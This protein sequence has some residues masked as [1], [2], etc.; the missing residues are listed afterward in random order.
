M[1]SISLGHRLDLVQVRWPLTVAVPVYPLFAFFYIDGTNA[2]TTF[3]QQSF[4][5]TGI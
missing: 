2:R 4:H 1:S 3:H 5:L